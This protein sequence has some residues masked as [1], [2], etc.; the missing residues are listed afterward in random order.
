M[1]CLLLYKSALKALFFTGEFSMNT[2]GERLEMA[3]SNA[4]YNQSKLAKAVGISQTSIQ[5]LCKKGIRSGYTPQIADILGV[6]A[7]WLAT[8][9]GEMKARDK[10][11]PPVI[12]FAEW[13]KINP[14]VR[15][16]VEDT[17]EKYKSNQITVDDVS[18]LQSM[19]D[20]FSASN[21]GNQLK[22]A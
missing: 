2:Y 22:H 6:D 13:Q 17:L 11:A 10:Q 8:G 21:A 18:F 14:K 16:F 7:E 1:Y 19:A 12:D 5:H 9:E 4:G 20:K 15:A 3:I